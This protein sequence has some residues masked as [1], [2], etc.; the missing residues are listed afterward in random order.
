MGDYSR[1]I[2]SGVIEVLIIGT[3]INRIYLDEIQPKIE[4]E[5]SRKINF[6]ISTTGT[7][8]PGLVIFER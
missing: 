6:M 4:K 1:G 8:Q 7:T 3:K 2:D 5:I